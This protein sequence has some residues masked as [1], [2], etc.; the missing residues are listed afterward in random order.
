MN[1]ASPP[2]EPALGRK[3]IR[4]G[5]LWIDSLTFK[6]ALDAI[7][8]LVAG[9]RGGTV[10]TPNV[11]HIVNAERDDR[12]RAAYQLVDLSL[13]DGQPV[14]WASHL[15]GTPLPEKLSGS[16]VVPR[17]LERAAAR[18]WRVYLLGGPAGAAKL[19]AEALQSKGVNLVGA[20]GPIIGITPRPDEPALLDR[21]HEARA[22]LLL[23]GLGSPK[24]EL[25]IHRAAPR[26]Q[27]TV[28]LGVGATIE[29]LAGT[30][31]RAPAWM[32]RAGLEWLFR[33]AMDPRRLARRYLWNDPR[34]AMV[35]LRTLRLPRETRLQLR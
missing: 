4:L 18:G 10:F 27:P 11:D 32:S 31:R 12:F 35:V 22:D 26:L 19:A 3:R 23:V 28:C 2:P 14:V 25:F 29:F 8:G 9:G 34:F 13:A 16:D 7:E 6:Q 20:E 24:Q 15:L 21:L 30:L 33:L 17:V 5:K 1:G